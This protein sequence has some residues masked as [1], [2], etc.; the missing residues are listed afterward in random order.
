MWPNLARYLVKQKYWGVIFLLLT[1]TSLLT[2]LCLVLHKIVKYKRSKELRRRVQ[3]L[4]KL[5]EFEVVYLYVS[6][7]V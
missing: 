4:E 2:K 3:T 1:V 7:V 5:L 6:W